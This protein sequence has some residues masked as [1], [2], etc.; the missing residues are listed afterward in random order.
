MRFWIPQ[1]HIHNHNDDCQYRYSL[2]YADGVGRTHGEGIETCWAEQNQTGGMVKEMNKGHRHDT[3]V[4]FSG[5]W[6]WLKTQQIGASRS[7][8]LNPILINWQELL[9]FMLSALLEAT[10]RDPAKT[11]NSCPVITT[12]LKSPSGHSLA[13]SQNSRAVNGRAC[14]ES[15]RTRVRTKLNIS[16]LFSHVNLVPSQ[17]SIYQNMLSEELRAQASEFRLS[18]PVAQFVDAGLKIQS[19][20]YVSLNASRNCTNQRSL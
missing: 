1:V 12:T 4:D 15:A 9:Y 20:Q 17:R 6:N 16:L 10:Q 8:Q 2:S 3:L 14:I 11:S 19:R 5:D 18:C 13:Q 7:P